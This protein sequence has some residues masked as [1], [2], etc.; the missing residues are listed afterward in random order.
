MTEKKCKIMLNIAIIWVLVLTV[1]IN[2]Q[3]FNCNKYK[4]S[5]I[6]EQERFDKAVE[7]ELVKYNKWKLEQ[8]K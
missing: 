2:I 6:N 1:F 4:T 3:L 8:P 5:V 7:D